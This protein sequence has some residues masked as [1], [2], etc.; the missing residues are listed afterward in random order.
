MAQITNKPENKFQLIAVS[1]LRSKQLID[2]AKPKI[3]TTAKKWT[4]IAR[5]EVSRGLVKFIVMNK[6]GGG[7]SPD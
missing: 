6:K 5:E 2:G 3:E 1:S 4:T 7:Q